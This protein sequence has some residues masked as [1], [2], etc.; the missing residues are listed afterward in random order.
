VPRSRKKAPP[1]EP[2][3]LTGV[4]DLILQPPLHWPAAPRAEIQLGPSDEGAGL[5]VRIPPGV[6][7]EF[8][9]GGLESTGIEKLAE[10]IPKPP[11][12]VEPVQPTAEA[13]P[14]GVVLAVSPVAT[15]ASLSSASSVPWFAGLRL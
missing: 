2:P 1:L 10:A 11:I 6:P 15:S 4:R 7:Y 12:L 9:L 13:L 3:Q 5:V 8:S 14:S